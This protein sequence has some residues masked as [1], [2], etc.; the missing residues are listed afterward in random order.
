MR[1][2]AF[3]V[4][5]VGVVLI[6]TALGMA[7]FEHD[8]SASELARTLGAE[9]DEHGGALE[10]YFAR[11]RSIILLTANSPAFANVLAEPGTRLE[12]VR[13]NGRSMR[14]VTHQLDYLEQ[15]YPT[16]IGE[17]C[18]IDAHGEEFARAVRGT[19]AR[20]DELSTSEEQT[21][22]FAPTFK[23]RFGQVH[24]TRPYVSPDTKEWVVANATLIPQPGGHKRA[25]VHFE[26]TV[27]S[28]R[29]EMRAA[30][31]T[32]R[33]GEFD[34]RVIDASTGRIVIDGARPQRV[35][36]ALGVPGDARFAPLA[37]QARPAGLTDV[38]GHLTAYRRIKSGA[39]NTNDWIVLATAKAPSGTFI[40]ELG[41]TPVA[42]LALA[43]V[44][45]ALAGLAL[46]AG[47]RR[48]EAEATTDGLTGLGNRRKF[49]AD[50]ERRARGAADAPIVLTML[51]LNGFKNYNDSFGHPA[52]DALLARMGAALA[53]AVGPLSGRAYRPGGDEFCV[54]APDARRDEIERAACHAL[55]DHGDGFSI[56]A[57]FGS[58]VIPHDAPDATEAVRKAD[59]MMYAHKHS[60]GTAA[61]RESSDVLMRALAER[62]PD[63][64]EH[65]D[66]VAE[67][68]EE[69]GRRFGIEGEELVQLRHAAS[70]HDIGKVAIPDAIITKPGPLS[71]EEWQFIR[72][73]TVIGERILTAA[74]SL[75]RA[76]RLVR[77]SHEAWDGSGYPDALA[78]TAI[79][80][81]ARIIAVCDSFD[82]M[83]S[84][85]PYAPAKPVADA[86][87]ELRRCAGTQFDPEIV[88]VFERVLADRAALLTA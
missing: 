65:H 87:A 12:K 31:A 55:S 10:N 40:A 77:S 11:A 45:I 81:G 16:S 44:T 46:R 23:L 14:E 38:D 41:R 78:G 47:R 48:L 29:R 3:A 69:V 39:G 1:M 43:F 80:L 50:L 36:A 67:L 74:P 19:L 34:L 8:R 70:L 72:R 17:A 7:K 56:S 59:Q 20:P 15:L 84:R 63:L 9:T 27:E 73:H 75:G 62:H 76:A 18:F 51:D 54:I 58:A 88:A 6:P 25:F 68:V 57:A 21:V 49:F 2:F 13:R 33:D 66:G 32:K 64:G 71:E 35:G 30:S 85:R 82:A 42:M 37:R 24:Q 60:G 79:P 4:L 53:A 86:V 83:I 61:G 5:I 28:F 26:V 52:G 22:F